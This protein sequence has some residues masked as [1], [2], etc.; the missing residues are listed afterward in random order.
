MC[1]C[2]L[3]CPTL[4]DPMDCSSSV[5]GIFQ[6]RILKWVAISSSRDLLNPVIESMVSCVSCSP[7]K[8]YVLNIMSMLKKKK[9]ADNTK[10]W[11]GNEVNDI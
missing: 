3:L 8:H 7:I 5:H 10:Y 2:A 9:K 1:A 11:Q 6:E 4:C